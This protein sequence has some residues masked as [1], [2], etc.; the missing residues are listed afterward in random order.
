MSNLTKWFDLNDPSGARLKLASINDVPHLFIT[1]LPYIHPKSQACV[2]ELAFHRVPSKSYLVRQAQAG[3]RLTESALRKV[4]A[5]A[6]MV[7]MDRAD[8]LIEQSTKTGHNMA[9]R[10]DVD[11]RGLIRLGRNSDGH[12]VYDSASGRLVITASGQR[13]SESDGGDFQE[14]LRLVPRQS[15][16][17][18]GEE[19]KRGLLRLSSGF[20]RSM[21][22]GEV[23]HTEDY[24]A[25]R[26]ALFAEEIERLGETEVPEFLAH[27][28]EML[29]AAID[30]AL[31]RHVR[32]TYDVAVDAYGAVARLYDYLPAY[33]GRQRGLA[34]MP[35]PLSVAAQRL[36]GDTTGKTVLYPQAYDGASFAFLPEGTHIRGCVS[37]RDFDVFRVERGDVEWVE[38]YSPISESG[39]D[40]LFF[41]MDPQPGHEEYRQAVQAIRSL[42]VGARAV[43]VFAAEDSQHPGKLSNTAARFLLLLSHSYSLDGVFETAPIL[44]RKAGSSNGLRVFALRNV[45]PEAQAADAQGTLVNHWVEQGVPVLCSWDQL[46]SHVTEL[47]ATMA[48]GEAQSKSVLA[49]RALANESYQRPYIAFSKIG[50]A[51]TMSPANLQG[52]AQAYLTRLEQVFGPVDD[53]VSA[54]L[55]MGK[56]TL[57]QRFSPE[58]IDAVAVMVSRFTA[59]RSSI[60]A[61][62]TGIGKGRAL[63][64]IATWANKRGHDVFFVTDRANL[65]SDLARDLNDIGEWDRFRPLVLNADGEITVD[66]GPNGAP[67]VLATGAKP[68]DMAEIVE[69][70]KSLASLQANIGFLT[71]SQIS[72]KD[73]PK[74]LWLKNQ[75]A[76]ALVIFDE[77][78]IAAG[79]DSNI[80]L[81]VSEIAALAA[82]VQF[83]SATWA[84]THDN[85][86]IYQR[87]L[88]ASVSMSTL[89]ETMRKGGDS[90]AEIFSTMLSAEGSLIRREHD[91]SK[92]EVEM[93]IDE[94]NRSHNEM[95][96]DLVADVLGAAAFVSGEM[97]QVFMRKNAE[98]VKKL[99]DARDARASSVRAKLFTANFGGGSVIY[100]VMK[101]VQGALNAPHVAKLAIESRAKG[102]KPVIVTDA[103][104]E[105]LV[106]QLIEEMRQEQLRLRQS[107]TAAGS[108]LPQ[109]D[110]TQIRIPTLRDALRLVVL[111]RL[112][113]VRVEVMTPEDVLDPIVPAQLPVD[114]DEDVVAPEDADEGVRNATPE[115]DAVEEALASAAP[116]QEDGVDI[117]AIHAVAAGVQSGQSNDESENESVVPGV[118]RR[119]RQYEEVSILQIEDMAPEAKEVYQKGLDEITAKINAV[120]QIPILGFDVIANTLAE[121]GISIGEI[122]GRKHQV[123]LID[124]KPGWG[125]LIARATSKKAV[126]ATIRAFNAG[127]I[128]AAI[129]NRSAAA[130]ISMHASPRFADQS[131]RHLIEHQIPEDPVNRVQLLGR[132]NRFDQLSSPLITTASTGIYGEVRYLMMQNRKLAR[133]SAN[134][135]SSRDNAMSLK[136]VTDLFNPVG[137]S[138]V[139]SFLLDN[140][141]IGRRLGI[142]DDEVESHP[143]LVNR[144]T[145]RIPLLTVVQQKMVYEDLYARFDEIIMR[146]E[147]EGS[148]PLRP[149]ELN[150]KAK[151][152]SEV[153]FFGD[154]S[155]DRGLVS[156]FD[157]PVYVRRIIWTEVLNPLRYENVVEAAK[158]A[159]QRLAQSG[160][161]QMVEVHNQIT[162]LATEQPRVNTAMVDK[163]VEAHH[164]LVRL[165][166]LA[167]GENCLKDSVIKHAAAKRAYIKY[168]WMKHNLALMVPGSKIAVHSNDPAN[169]LNT[170]F[171]AILITDV[172]PPDQEKDWMDAG[173]WR[174]TTVTTGDERARSYTLRSLIS[175]VAGEVMEGGVTGD[176]IAMRT[177]PFVGPGLYGVSQEALRNMFAFSPSGKRTR[178][179]NVLTGN[180]Y[181]AAEWSAAVGK[182]VAINYTDAGG[183]RHRVIQLPNEMSM[184]DPQHLPIRLA[185]SLMLQRFMTPLLTATAYNGLAFDGVHVLDTSF[186]SAMA[187]ASGAVMSKRDAVLAVLPMNMIAMSCSPKDARRIRAALSS[188]QKAMRIQQLGEG[189]RVAS[190]PAN[191]EIRMH[192]AAKEIRKLPAAI[193]PVLSGVSVVRSNDFLGIDGVSRAAKESKAAVITMKFETSQ[194]AA[195]AIDLMRM[196]SGLEVYATSADHKS[197]AREV[198]RQTMVERRQQ[199]EQL[200]SQTR[201]QIER[202]A[203]VAQI[204][205]EDEVQGEVQ[206]EHDPLPIQIT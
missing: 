173:K 153:V 27:V 150:V 121:R 103:T 197:L 83:A 82:Y 12:V 112:S 15:P 77:A 124:G 46:K 86:H 54:E 96:S 177:G 32:Q 123:K 16:M 108:A 98:S 63:A 66:D 154:D 87:A 79:S 199:I 20:I 117:H 156:A 22:A 14:F 69:R 127:T 132:V 202:A 186:R 100:Q 24:K 47:M 75:L 175:A 30:A 1:G 41:N 68:A 43:L 70:N 101:T 84:K 141:L 57:A 105:A 40:A 65:F 191:V 201:Q 67:R 161:L 35:Q 162:G 7:M 206:D 139:R 140:P 205:V 111:K 116:A 93:V 72:G 113:M 149:H 9:K 3:E 18:D 125:R 97:Q 62:D 95:V 28:D 167:T 110:V 115:G 185:D 23:Q 122:S 160:Y 169:E 138:A 192:T 179:S 19:L 17:V 51:R 8:F 10:M 152:D 73:S 89:T 176:L 90:F 81:Q 56:H 36:L 58:Q 55:G 39:A 6:R 74:G 203:E 144:L 26:S 11:L 148:N 158:I 137:K 42:A 194:Q 4:F 49:E 171:T 168:D 134:V 159:T 189:A 198:I 52:S 71:Y 92:L 114:I 165:A 50:E 180:M 166:H 85:L 142:S 164:S 38:G 102:L 188:G 163:I 29:C 106:G 146:A 34:A 61:D 187:A 94:A 195:R 104:G 109:D 184:I 37:G 2:S 157:A 128:D 13:R 155:Q 107:D 59:G 178:L 196:H 193:A 170:A 130:G 174:I 131:R 135:R 48:I 143:D 88:P 200:Q 182:G 99:K 25:F 190:D 151:T 136:G 21:D 5:N 64:A 91:L 126:K 204:V 181:L 53:F 120:P 78:H 80:A 60:L 33:Q 118:K 31:L 147:M 45:A 119:R 129:I 145:M 133:M 183:Q 172:K 44:S 76:N